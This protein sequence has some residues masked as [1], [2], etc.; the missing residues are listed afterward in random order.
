[1]EEIMDP[2]G[3]NDTE[4][5]VTDPDNEDTAETEDLELENVNNFLTSVLTGDTENLH[6]CFEGLDDPNHEKANRLLNIHDDV[7]RNALHIASML[8]H[9]EV[10]KELVAQGANVNE[11][12]S[13]GYTPLHCGAAWGKLDS[14]KTLVELGASVQESS[15]RNEKARD[16]ANRYSKT[17]CTEF[18]D[19]AEVKL[20]LELYINN[21]QET[22]ADLEKVQGKLTKHDKTIFANACRAKSDWLHSAQNASVQEFQ[23]QKKL[24]EVTVEP[25]MTKL[26][27]PSPQSRKP[28]KTQTPSLPLA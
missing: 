16:I 7:G 3:E 10:I 2:D 27:T 21:I 14:L 24:L 22:V 9:C 8:G 13:R 12:T 4:K 25:I 1:M 18:L 6:K 11:K 17:D 20:V 23:E 26:T 19:W 5:E 28:S 15:F